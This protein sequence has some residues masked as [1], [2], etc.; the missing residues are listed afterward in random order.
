MEAK[1]EKIINAYIDHLL[2]QQKRPTSVFHFMRSLKMKEGFFYD[3][4]NS[5]A[6]LE[7]SIWLETFHETK[8][9]IESDEIYQ[10]YSIREKMLAFYY[11]WIE[12]LKQYRS[13]AQYCFGQE[14]LLEF[15]PESLDLLKKE[16]TEFAIQLIE[17]G[18]TKGEIANRLYVSDKYG[19]WL[20]P[21]VIFI[22]KFWLKDKSENFEKT[23]AAIE[24][25][26]NFAFD[27]M[28]SNSID[29]FID[30]TKFIFER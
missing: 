25:S 6:A 15:W 26:V 17:E 20:W 5:F 12:V 14:G 3:H 28:V 4:F 27:L 18:K 30:L 23:D 13:F 9:R 29:S 16:F 11:A 24:K 19:P 21:Q 10:T 7:K 1:Q 22:L 8:K 2:S